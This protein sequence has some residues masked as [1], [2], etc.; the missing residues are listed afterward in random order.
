MGIK[1]LTSQSGSNTKGPL[2]I[3]GTIKSDI[4]NNWTELVHGEDGET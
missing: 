4:N 3:I 2:R 1:T